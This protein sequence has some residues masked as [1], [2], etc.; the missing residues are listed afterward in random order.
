[1]TL[2]PN[3]LYKTRRKNPLVHKV[4]MDFSFWFYTIHLG[5]SRVAGYNFPK[6]IVFHYLKIGFGLTNSTDPDEM[7][8]YAAFHL[9][10]SLFAEVLI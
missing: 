5:W 9:G 1:M 7:S 4:P 10:L 2:I 3:V 6:N 8:D